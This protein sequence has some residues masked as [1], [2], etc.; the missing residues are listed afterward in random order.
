MA[1]FVQ[2]VFWGSSQNGILMCQVLYVRKASEAVL[3]LQS[4]ILGNGGE[5]FTQGIFSDKTFFLIKMHR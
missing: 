4:K 1:M 3:G 2:V 5:Y